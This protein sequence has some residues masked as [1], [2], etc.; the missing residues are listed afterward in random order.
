M[1]DIPFELILFVLF[2]ALPAIGN[3]LRRRSGQRR[4]GEQ[5]ARPTTRQ[6]DTVA[7]RTPE[8]TPNAPASGTPDWLEEARRRVAEARQHEAEGRQA[9]TQ[10]SSRPSAPP[11]ASPQTPSRP[12]APRRTSREPSETRPQRSLEGRSLEGRSAAQRAPHQS[13]E[14]GSLEHTSL[15]RSSLETFSTLGDQA[16]P[17]RTQRLS[18]SKRATISKQELRFDA[19]DL[20]KGLIW[21]QVLSPPRSTLRRTRLSRRRP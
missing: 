19:H 17:L 11:A 10:R 2:F 16:P 7:K 3:L 4:A 13:L 21:H 5:T 12:V 9:G 8:D 20:A 18:S 1:P 6:P 14:G 15:E